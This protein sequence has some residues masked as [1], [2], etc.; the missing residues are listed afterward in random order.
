MKTED[1]LE[2]GLGDDL[3]ASGAGSDTI[4]GGAGRDMILSATGFNLQP[5]RNRDNDGVLDDW[6]PLAGAGAVRTSRRLW[7]IYADNQ[8]SET[9]EGGGPESQDRA[10]GARKTATTR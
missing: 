1:I 10:G 2:G 5:Q 9:I 3:L 4:Y 8:G 6:A 7:G